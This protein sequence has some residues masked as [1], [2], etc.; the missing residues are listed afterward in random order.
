MRLTYVHNVNIPSKSANTVQV[1]RMCSAFAGAGC[2]V[3]LILPQFNDAPQPSIAETLNEYG[4]EN[5]FGIR[6]IRHDFTG[7][8]GYAWRASAR[9]K[10]RKSDLVYGR[11]IRSC[12]A[13]A[14]RGLRVAHEAHGPLNSYSKS[15]QAAFKWLTRSPLFVRL[16]VVTKSLA[17]HYVN[18]LPNIARPPLVEPNGTDPASRIEPIRDLPPEARMR[19]G[20]VGS[21]HA[22]KGME[23]I[24]QIAQSTDHEIVVAGGDNEVI[25]RW[26][27]EVGGRVKF[28]GHVPSRDVSDLINTFDVALAPYLPVVEGAGSTFNLAEYMSPLKIFEYMAHGRPI[29]ASNLP[30]VSSLVSNDRELLLCD[31]T[32]PSEWTAAIDLLARDTDLRK[33]LGAQALET[34][35]ERYQRP[36]RAVR[37]LQS[38]SLGA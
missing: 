20:Y 4:C 34:F 22:G 28:L 9:A 26:K 15:G 1:M 2:D 23:L 17:S 7:S 12:A 33:R 31:P 10:Q 21:L 37:I 27:A 18:A 38:L 3:E 35:T 16:V 6:R 5:A 19:I 36:E 25:A 32:Q 24:A 13:S 30:E 14:W 8:F 29:I 11:C